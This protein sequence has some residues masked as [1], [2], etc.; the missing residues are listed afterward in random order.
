MK[1]SLSLGTLEATGSSLAPLGPL[2]DTFS[3]IAQNND[4]VF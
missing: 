3:V 1:P 2:T 4:T